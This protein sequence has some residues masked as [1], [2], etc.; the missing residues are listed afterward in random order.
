MFWIGML[1][2]W[3]GEQGRA[4]LFHLLL[5]VEPVFLNQ[6]HDFGLDHSTIPIFGWLYSVARAE[7]A[8]TN[9]VAWAK[10]FRICRNH[11]V[12]SIHSAD[13]FL[14]QLGR[15]I[16]SAEKLSECIAAK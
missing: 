16:G 8:V 1:T 4:L 6:G 3:L 10:V 13:D 15:Y 12:Q 14:A 7:I 5:V 9:L 2:S 11:L